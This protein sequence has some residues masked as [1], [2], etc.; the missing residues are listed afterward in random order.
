MKDN[1]STTTVKIILILSLLKKKRY[2][3]AELGEILSCT[4]RHVRRLI[5]GI[6]AAGIDVKIKRG[7]N[8]GYKIDNL[9]F[10]VSERLYEKIILGLDGKT[11]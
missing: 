2:T 1:I 5:N 10:N 11:T 3:A 9:D 6:I 7:Q 4:D 8:G